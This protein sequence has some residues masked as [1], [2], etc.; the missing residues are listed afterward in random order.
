M[1]PV[2]HRILQRNT[3]VSLFCRAW[4]YEL[5]CAFPVVWR[6]CGGE[7]RGGGVTHGSI[8][9]VIVFPPH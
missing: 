1:Y 3:F 9:C 8:P 5:E 7:R 4:F 2:V 6:K